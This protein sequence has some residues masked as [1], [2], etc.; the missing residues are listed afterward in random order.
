MSYVH[1]VLQVLL[2]FS[3]DMLLL[4][5]PKVAGPNPVVLDTEYNIY[6]LVKNKKKHLKGRGMQY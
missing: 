2:W 1:T 3:G 4:V 6:L 5:T